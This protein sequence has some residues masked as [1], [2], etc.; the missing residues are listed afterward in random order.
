MGYV[1]HAIDPRALDRIRSRKTD[2]FGNPFVVRVDEDGGSPLR[3]CLRGSNAG[4]RIALIAYRPSAA[5]GPY[6][7]VG[8]VF[9]HHEACAGWE[10]DGYPTA[11]TDR[12]Q[13]FR[14]YDGAGRIVDARLVRPGE[15]D[16][17]IAALLRDEQ[18]ARIDTR[19]V[20][21]GCFMTTITRVAG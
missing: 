4:E 9:V 10:V 3:C 15:H 13:V 21:Y 2:D 1:V 5:G 6:A 20:L 18:V 14:A 8:P 12:A 16:D 7:E 19:N 17:T 11:F